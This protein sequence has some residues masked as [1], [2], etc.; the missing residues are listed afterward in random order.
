MGFEGDRVTKLFRRINFE[1]PEE[2]MRFAVSLK[3]MVSMKL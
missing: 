1:N 2:V 3:K